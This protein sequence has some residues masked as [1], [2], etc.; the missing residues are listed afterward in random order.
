MTHKPVN[1]PQNL[2]LGFDID[3]DMNQGSYTQ[4]QIHKTSLPMDVATFKKRYLFGIPFKDEDGNEPDEDF[5]KHHLLMATSEIETLVGIKITPTE[6][7]DE[8]HDYYINEHKEWSFIKTFQYPILK[9]VKVSAHY[10]S[11]LRLYDFPMDWVKTAPSGGQINLVPQSGTIAQVILSNSGGHLPPMFAGLTHIPNLWHVDYV[12]GFQEGKI[13]HNVADII[14][15]QAAINLLLIAGELIH[16]VGI[17]NESISADALSQSFGTT[18]SEG[19]AFSGRI[20]TYTK[21][22]EDGVKS[23]KAY[24]KGINFQVA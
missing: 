21:Q 3:S 12:A 17:A 9:V 7:H 5:F 18:K 22:V 19:N 11:S 4:E 16:G 13:P 1:N 10:P 2:P 20:K 14:G 15:K 8:Q 24:W 6:I 23:L